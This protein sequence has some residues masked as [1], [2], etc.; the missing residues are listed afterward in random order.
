MSVIV[1]AFAG[2]QSAPETNRNENA[3]AA[4]SPPKETFD[5]AAIEAEVM[6][7]ERDWFKAGQTYDAELIKQIVAE[8]A[9][10]VYPDGSTGTKADELR[11]VETKA[12]TVDSWEIPEAKVT[13]LSADSAFITG[14]SVVKNGKIK[15]TNMPRPVDISGEY[16][17]VDVYARI[18]GKW[19]V[20]ASAAAKV[21]NP[22]LPAPATASPAASAPPSP[23]RPSPTATRTASP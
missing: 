15:D 12:I 9:I 19:Q 18:N 10:L 17:F 21:Q 13:V 16:R 6:K 8:D 23:P 5:A 2:C 20:V 7:L 11:L 3:I 22:V 14:R 4:A 1:M